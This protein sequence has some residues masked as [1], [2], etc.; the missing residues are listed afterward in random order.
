M[1]SKSPHQLLSYIAHSAPATRRPAV[2]DEQFIRPEIGF[3]PK[4]YTDRLD[5]GFDARWH[6]DPAYR[7]KAI[8]AMSEETSRRFGGKCDI[9]IMQQPDD[10]LDILTGTYGALLV[11]GT[12]GVP[13]EYREKD[14]PWSPPGVFLSDEEAENLEP[15][16]LDENA[17]WNEFTGQLDQIEKMIGTIAGFMNWQGVLNNAFRLRGGKIFSDMVKAPE[18]VD[19]VFEC[20]AETM[21]EGVKRL[22]ERQ[23]ETGFE[24]H[25]YTISN[26]LVNMTSPAQYSRFQLPHD[27]RIARSFS[28][29]GVHNCAWNA[30]PYLEAYSGIPEVAYIDMSMDSDL[31]RVREM[32]PDARRAIMYPPDDIKNKSGRELRRDLEYIAQHYG[33]CDMVFA[34]IEDGTP[35]ERVHL[36]IDICNE[37]S[38]EYE[39]A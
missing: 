17:F 34:D 3:V 26:C 36:I 32:F 37:I 38:A 1:K 8:T 27:K 7:R 28:F 33:P 21:I 18:R 13:I 22:Y 2:G 4:W 25:H 5:I 10:P 39:D 6:T 19:H 23:G 14:W 15:P 20:V 31:E 9:G 12:Y 11:S 29:I 24:L 16:D 30:D 35:D